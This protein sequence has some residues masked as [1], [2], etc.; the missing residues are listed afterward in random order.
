MVKK[1]FVILEKIDDF[2]F[3]KISRII[4]FENWEKGR[5]F[6]ENGSSGGNTSAKGFMPFI[7]ATVRQMASQKTIP[8]ST[9]ITKTS[10]PSSGEQR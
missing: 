7:S 5:I 8:T 10:N 1:T 9:A 3:S 6:N 4:P 2:Q